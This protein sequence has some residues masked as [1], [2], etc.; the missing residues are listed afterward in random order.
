MINFDEI[1]KFYLKIAY[2]SIRQIS[3]KTPIHQKFPLP[4][5]YAIRYAVHVHVLCILLVEYSSIG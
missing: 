2:T 5:I 3:R 4:K 1:V